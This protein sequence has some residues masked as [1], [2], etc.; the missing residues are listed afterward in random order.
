MRKLIKVS[1]YVIKF[2]EKKKLLQYLLLAEE[3]QFSYVMLFINL[4]KLNIFRIIMSKQLL[5]LLKVMRALK[6]HQDAV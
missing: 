5:S 1:D 2:L 6:N 3:A 4:K